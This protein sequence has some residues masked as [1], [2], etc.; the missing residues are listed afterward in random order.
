M[1]EKMFEEEVV[2][3]AVETESAENAEAEDNGIHFG[4]SL[5]KVGKWNKKD[6]FFIN[7]FDFSTLDG[8]IHTAIGVFAIYAAIK[9]HKIRKQNKK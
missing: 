6:S 9:L 5:F 4:L 3:E 1:E 7:L 2:E 8:V